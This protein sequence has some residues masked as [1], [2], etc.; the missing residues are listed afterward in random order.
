[1]FLL[2]SLLWLIWQ[3]IFQYL[4]FIFMC[5]KCTHSGWRHKISCIRAQKILLEVAADITS[6]TLRSFQHI[7]IIHGCVFCRSPPDT[8]LQRCE[9]RPSHYPKSES[10]GFCFISPIYSK[11]LMDTIIVTDDGPICW[12]THSPDDS[13]FCLDFCFSFLF[14][15]VCTDIFVIMLL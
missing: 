4:C 6:F 12:N 9:L 15:D 13:I 1:M 3:K 14:I 11:L 2:R 8:L 10:N 5:R 7:G